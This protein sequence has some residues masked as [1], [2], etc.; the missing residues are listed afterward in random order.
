M[1]QV[2]FVE[3]QLILWEKSNLLCLCFELIVEC[4][5][6]SVALHLTKCLAWWMPPNDCQPPIRRSSLH[7]IPFGHYS[8]WKGTIQLAALGHF[9]LPLFKRSIWHWIPVFMH[10]LRL[11]AGLSEKKEG[12]FF[13]FSLSFFYAI[14]CL[15]KPLMPIQHQHQG[16]ALMSIL[17]ADLFLSLPPAAL[18]LFSSLSPFI[19]F[20]SLRSLFTVTIQLNN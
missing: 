10:L 16:T 1:T 12:L 20:S 5:V 13:S 14:S 6:T 2:I 19:P 17:A 15:Q 11:L 4:G 7:Y 9:S 8:K 3:L 18:S